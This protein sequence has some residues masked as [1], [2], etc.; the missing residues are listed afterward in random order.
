VLAVASQDIEA[1]R[2]LLDDAWRDSLDAEHPDVVVDFDQA[3]MTC[4]ACL[5]KFATGPRECP[6]CGLFLG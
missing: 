6:D 4:P 5:T 1:T 2:R 3:E